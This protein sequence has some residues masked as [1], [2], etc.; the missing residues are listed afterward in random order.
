MVFWHTK[1]CVLSSAPYEYPSFLQNERSSAS[2]SER[3]SHCSTVYRMKSLT[4]DLVLK[5]QF[6][7]LRCEKIIFLYNKKYLGYASNSGTSI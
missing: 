3:K 5:M 2:S 4:F 7:K 6:L 1:P